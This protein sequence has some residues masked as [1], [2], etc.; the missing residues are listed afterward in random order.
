MA[1]V[2]W[3]LLRLAFNQ[4]Y[5]TLQHWAGVRFYT[6]LLN[7]AKSYVFIKQ[8]LPSLFFLY[9]HSLSRSYR[10]NLPSSFNTIHS[11][12]VVYST[13]LLVLELVR[14]IYS[15]FPDFLLSFLLKIKI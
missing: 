10:V 1:A 12:V 11:F 14:L 2:Y 6:S 3:S 13:N 9:T 5:F 4:T 15:F 8:S 7:F